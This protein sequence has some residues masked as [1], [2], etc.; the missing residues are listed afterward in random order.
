MPRS[1]FGPWT[2]GSKRLI[3]QQTHQNGRPG[4]TISLR[5]VA[6]SDICCALAAVCVVLFDAGSR[7]RRRSVSAVDSGWLQP[8]V[9]PPEQ[10]CSGMI[11]SSLW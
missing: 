8:A 1:L 4:G 11:S 10:Q 7:S 6:G 2:V 9:Q 5:R 3:L